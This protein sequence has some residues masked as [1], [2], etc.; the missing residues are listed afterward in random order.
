MLRA[1]DLGRWAAVPPLGPP[2]P[3]SRLEA[4]RKDRTD[5]QPL[6]RHPHTP[7]SAQGQAQQV[8]LPEQLPQRLLFSGGP[9]VLAGWGQK[10]LEKTSKAERGQGGQISPLLT[11]ALTLE[12]KTFPLLVSRAFRALLQPVSYK[13]PLGQCLSQPRCRQVGPPSGPDHPS[14]LG[15]SGWAPPHCCPQTPTV[16]TGARLAAGQQWGRLPL[17]PPLGR[18]SPCWLL[19]GQT[20]GDK[21][22]QGGA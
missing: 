18:L 2:T 20:E 13:L 8:L 6:L 14:S 1:C 5:C 16:G 15:K 21:G 9:P 10:R 7:L 19:V 11:F 22:P 12:S 4:E 3:W 17:K